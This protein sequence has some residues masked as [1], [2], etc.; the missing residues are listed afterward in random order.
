MFAHHSFTDIELVR[1][2]HGVENFHLRLFRDRLHQ[3]IQQTQA[4]EKLVNQIPRC[5][6]D[7]SLDS[8]VQQIREALHHCK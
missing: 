8:I 5:H 7:E 2:A 4:I 1:A 6:C 3:R